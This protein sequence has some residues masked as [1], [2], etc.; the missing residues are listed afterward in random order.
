LV[1]ALGQER[2][3]QEN[4]FKSGDS[5]RFQSAGETGEMNRPTKEQVEQEDDE[6]IGAQ[7]V[8]SPRAPSEKKAQ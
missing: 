6:R 4:T 2:I 7:G 1:R 5:L 8:S 3:F